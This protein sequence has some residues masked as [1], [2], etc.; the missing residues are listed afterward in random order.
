MGPS[1]VDVLLCLQRRDPGC[2]P[3][4]FEVRM[5]LVSTA[6]DGVSKSSERSSAPLDRRR[7][8]PAPRAV[9]PAVRAPASID[10]VARVANVP[11]AGYENLLGA[12]GDALTRSGERRVG[13]ESRAG[14]RG[15][16]R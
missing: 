3:A 7:V 10:V 1:L 2:L 11:H 16:V 14:C 6:Q 9:I 5:G 15:E 12:D 4:I 8:A 13:E